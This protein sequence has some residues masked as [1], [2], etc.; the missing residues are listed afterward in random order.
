VIY[1]KSVVYKT[2][3]CLYYEPFLYKIEPHRY[4]TIQ[5]TLTTML[6]FSVKWQW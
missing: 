1:V 3:L 4:T 5:C 6:P 2:K